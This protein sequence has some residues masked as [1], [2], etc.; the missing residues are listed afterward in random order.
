MNGNTGR[1]VRAD[2]SSGEVVIESLPEALYRQYIGGSGLAAAYFRQY[3]D[4]AAGP[5]DP[6]AMLI[7][8]NGPFAGLRLSGASR[9]SVAGRSPLTG[10]WADASCGG[11]FAPALRYA[12]YDGIAITGQAAEPVWLNITDA[13]VALKSAKDLW[14]LATDETDR[15]LKA[16]CGRTCRALTIGPAGE[17]R[18]R[19]ACILNE[20]HHAFGRAGFGAVMGA[21]RLKAVT[22]TTSRRQM[23]L[24]DPHGY[25]AL[26]QTLKEQARESVTG[27]VLGDLGT[28]AKLEYQAL[29][30]DVPIRNWTS[31]LW[32]EMGE[33]LTGST[34]A[35]TYLVGRH[36]CAYCRIA[37]KRV[38]Q[39]DE[40]PFAVSRGPGPEYETI[41]AFGSLLGSMDLAAT[42]KAGRL[43]NQL[44]MD[45][46]SAGATIAW[47][48]EAF[49]K[50]VLTPE[51]TGGIPLQWGDMPTVIDVVLPAMAHRR[52]PLGE[53][54]S[55]GSRAAA[56]RIGHGSEEFTVHSKGLEAPMHDP[57]GGGH[58]LALAYAVSPR[59]ACHVATSMLPVEAGA[60]YYPEIGFTY[61]LEPLTDVHKAEAAVVAAELGAIENSACFCQF[62]DRDMTI[63][64]WVDLFNTVA[65]YDWDAA[66]MMAAG[67]RVFYLK[68]LLNEGFGLTAA[69]DDLSA[70][71]REPARDGEPEGV[72]IALDAMRDEFYR[73][74]GLDSRR[75]I[76]TR[77]ALCACGMDDEAEQAWSAPA[78]PVRG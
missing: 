5:L 37:C 12:G 23:A 29:C 64:Q 32:P 61:E 51:D 31:N 34:L 45:T 22:V 62:A 9:N 7:L 70:R 24:A 50:K 44:G 63:G 38:V 77:E 75:G 39:V 66:A 54:L 8:M 2:L 3:G 68:R 4:P 16:E 71:L 78:T 33:A 43:C 40:G 27:Q 74:M 58:G 73:L 76:P 11:W 47:A 1:I 60:C 72:E 46:I 42:C 14:G 20:A 65:G 57:R 67:R 48:M 41:A 21:K 13:G 17:N 59:G 25:E 10:V 52:G 55:L 6:Q 35:E 28:A 56:R 36:S 19:Y 26:R 18:V 49:A 69:D 53:L 15:R 30:G